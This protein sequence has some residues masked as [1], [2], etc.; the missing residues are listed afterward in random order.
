MLRQ[1]RCDRQPV[2]QGARTDL[3]GQSVPSKAAGLTDETASTIELVE[4]QSDGVWVA[5]A[6]ITPRRELSGELAAH[7]RSPR[8]TEL[9]MRV[10]ILTA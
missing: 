9:R 2:L 7:V 10:T 6:C 4:T 5:I 3:S 1:R 8:G